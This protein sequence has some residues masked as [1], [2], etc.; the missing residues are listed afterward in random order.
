MDVHATA[1]QRRDWTG[2][3]LPS[4]TTT[5]A[6]PEL[7]TVTERASVP[8]ATAA[9]SGVTLYRSVRAGAVGNPILCCITGCQGNGA[10]RWKRRRLSWCGRVAPAQSI[11]F[12]IAVPAPSP[13][14][15]RLALFPLAVT[16]DRGAAD[17]IQRINRGP[18][19]PR[20]PVKFKDWSTA[21]LIADA[22]LV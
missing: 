15:L 18:L 19:P 8:E 21:K 9:E 6:L 1:C 13:A 4:K 16:N 14:S 17:A 5:V 2:A 22:A 7:V 11:T 3:P 12:T 20:P 10:R